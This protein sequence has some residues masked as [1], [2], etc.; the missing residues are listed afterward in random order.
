MRK[1]ALFTNL[2]SFKINRAIVAYLLSDY[3][4]F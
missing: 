4:L 3:Y 1:W 2:L